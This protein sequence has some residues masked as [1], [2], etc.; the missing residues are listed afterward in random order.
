MS[1]IQKKIIDKSGNDFIL[2][3]IKF[4]RDIIK[5]N[6]KNIKQQRV[7]VMTD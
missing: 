4:A 2:E 7:I 3:N 1:L 5:I 6:D